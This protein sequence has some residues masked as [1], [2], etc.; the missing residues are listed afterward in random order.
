VLIFG[1]L[2][3][4]AP[5]GGAGIVELST[6]I[7]AAICYL[8]ALWFMMSVCVLLCGLAPK[9]SALNWVVFAYSFG[10]VY[11]GR[12]FDLPELAVKLSPFGSVPQLPVQEFNAAPLIILTVIAVALTALGAVGF[13]RRDAG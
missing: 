4:Y 6:M 8:P 2:G 13:N 1:A 11:F 12:L 10:A 3:L 5:T 7:K 9:L